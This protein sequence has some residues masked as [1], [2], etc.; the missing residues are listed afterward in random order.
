MERERL[1]NV[2]EASFAGHFGTKTSRSS[3]SAHVKEVNNAKPK[4]LVVDDDHAVR[5]SLRKLLEA[6]HYNVHTAHGGIDALNHFT[7][8]SIDL[9]VL[10]LNLSADDGWEVFHMM[11]ETNPF[12]PTII[13]TAESDQLERAVAAG[14]E[15]L[16]EKPIDVS[17]FLKTISDLL[18]QTSEQRLERVC[19]DDKYCRYIARH[20][21]PFL[22]LLNERQSTPLKLSSSLSAALSTLQIG[23]ASDLGGNLS[24]AS[25]AS[26]SHKRKHSNESDVIDREKASR[27]PPILEFR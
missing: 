15:A 27:L 18:A 7:F 17:S 24:M 2:G 8:N 22:K 5:E 9:V 16:I 19:G 25:Y 26:D 12:V 13:I 20:S 21:E 4:L 14:V 11:A 6:E 3:G 23:E 1:G 10:D